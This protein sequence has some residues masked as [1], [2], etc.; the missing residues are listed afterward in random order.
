MKFDEIPGQGIQEHEPLQ[1]FNS[2]L[3]TFQYAAAVV[4]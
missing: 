2:S 1:T 3:L 4:L